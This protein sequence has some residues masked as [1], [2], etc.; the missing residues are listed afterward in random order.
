MKKNVLALGGIVVDKYL[1]VEKYPIKGGDTFIKENFQSVGGCATNVAVTL[2]NLNCTPYIVSKIGSD[3]NGEFIKKYIEKQCFK[4][5]FIKLEENQKTGYCITIVDEEGE[6]TFMTYTGCENQLDYSMIKHEII[7][8]IDFVYLTAYYILDEENFQEK[9]YV[10]NNIKNQGGKI[11][12][13]PGALVS[14]VNLKNLEQVLKLTDI[15]V[16][17]EK[18]KKQICK[19]FS[20]KEEYFLNYCFKKGINYIMVKKGEKG[21]YAYT[22]EKQYKFNGY[23]VN[24]VDT[25]GAGDSFA[26]GCIY[27]F[28]MNYSLEN[29]LKIG[30]ACGAIATTKIGPN[31]KF[32]EKDVM[33]LVKGD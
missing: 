6:R 19:V 15:I 16:P 33:K 26:A 2:K 21:A 20:I 14:S 12:F 10:L 28:L 25:T 23:N 30:C 13:D 9:L 18:E 32:N 29:I 22:K 4:E 24:S 17:N 7:K 1:L 11:M 3:E 31:V 8:N 5:D 27:G